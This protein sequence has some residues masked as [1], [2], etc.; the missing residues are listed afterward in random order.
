MAPD[1]DEVAAAGRAFAP[2]P[3]AVLAV[4]VDDPSAVGILAYLD[5]RRIAAREHVGEGGSD[6]RQNRIR[7]PFQ[8]RAGKRVP[9]LVAAKLTD[10]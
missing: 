6:L 4:V 7:S 10:D 1:L 5:S 2:P 8:R 3:S 9:V